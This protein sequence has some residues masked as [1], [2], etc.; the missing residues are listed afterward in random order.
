MEVVGFEPTPL[1]PFF[2][3]P[4]RLFCC[5]FQKLPNKQVY[6]FYSFYCYTEF[7]TKKII[8]EFSVNDFQHQDARG[9]SWVTGMVVMPSNTLSASSKALNSASASAR[10]SATNVSSHLNNLIHF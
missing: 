7:P 6:L 3:T 10:R 1:Y 9:I 8:S 2:Q 5:E 4:T